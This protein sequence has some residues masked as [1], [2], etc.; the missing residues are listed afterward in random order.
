MWTEHNYVAGSLPC[1]MSAPTNGAVVAVHF[2]T[3]AE[4]SKFL[5]TAQHANRVPTLWSFS[6]CV[7]IFPQHCHFLSLIAHPS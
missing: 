2:V 3:K 6:I 7:K 4:S 5:R 1:G